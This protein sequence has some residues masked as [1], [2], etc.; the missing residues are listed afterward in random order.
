M[1]TGATANGGKAILPS[2]PCRLNAGA[3]QSN[4]PSGLLVKQGKLKIY[5][6]IFITPAVFYL[7]EGICTSTNAIR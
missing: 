2:H 1:G 4:V 6:S 3:P 7:C 5:L